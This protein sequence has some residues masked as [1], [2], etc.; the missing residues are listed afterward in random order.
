[1]TR[2]SRS[3][4][5]ASITRSL[6]NQVA[7]QQVQLEETSIKEVVRLNFQFDSRLER[8]RLD[9]SRL[10]VRIAD[11]EGELEDLEEANRILTERVEEIRFSVSDFVAGMI[12]AMLTMYIFN[13]L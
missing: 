6:Q 10:R 3:K 2:T 12:I 11:L 5:V 9:N 13:K 1:M 4:S 7:T 8:V